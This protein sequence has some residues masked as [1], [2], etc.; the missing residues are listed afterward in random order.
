MEIDPIYS[1]ND[2]DL[3]TGREVKR[4]LREVLEGEGD[5]EVSTTEASELLGH[6]SDW[7]RRAAPEIPGARQDAE[8]GPWTLPLVACRAHL[9][10]LRHEGK[11][12]RRHATKK[13]FGRGPWKGRPAPQIS[14]VP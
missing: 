4:M 8:G 9:S 6:S 3:F 11:L 1:I 13:P 10:D 7:W 2:N 14:A 5:V 12:R